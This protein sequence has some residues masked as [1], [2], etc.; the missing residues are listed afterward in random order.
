M[1]FNSFIFL[2]STCNIR[3]N[4]GYLGHIQISVGKTI[5]VYVIHRL[6]P[7]ISSYRIEKQCTSQH[8][9]LRRFILQRPD[10]IQS[11]QTS[12]GVTHVYNPIVQLINQYISFRCPILVDLRAD[13]NVMDNLVLVKQALQPVLHSSSSL[14]EKLLD[15]FTYRS[16]PAS[17]WQSHHTSTIFLSFHITFIGSWMSTCNDTARRSDL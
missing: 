8:L 3:D 10:Q 12:W 15:S 1:F 7:D 14:D 5:R 11:H 6:P 4:L 17:H 9:F 16:P 13:N 2:M